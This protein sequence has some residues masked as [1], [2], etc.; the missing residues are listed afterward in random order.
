MVT[1]SPFAFVIDSSNKKTVA[2]KMSATVDCYLD[3]MILSVSVIFLW[4]LMMPAVLVL[5]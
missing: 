1:P 4:F 5:A 2:S 3:R